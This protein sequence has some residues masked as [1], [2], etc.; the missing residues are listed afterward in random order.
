MNYRTIAGAG[1]QQSLVWRS[2]HFP[3]APHFNNLERISRL[4]Y[5]DLLADVR[6]LNECPEAEA[7]DTCVR[8]VRG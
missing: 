5:F 8:E 6:I 2:N 4:T 1:N 7:L 3:R